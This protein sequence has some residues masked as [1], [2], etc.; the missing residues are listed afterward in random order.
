MDYILDIL[1]SSVALGFDSSLQ[2]FYQHTPSLLLIRIC[3]HENMQKL[4]IR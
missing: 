3:L 4:H 1:F 2:I